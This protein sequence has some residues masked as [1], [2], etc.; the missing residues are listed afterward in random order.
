[1]AETL[2]LELKTSARDE[3][4]DVTQLVRSAT[5]RAQVDSG[6]ALVFCPHT[7]AG[8]TLQENTDPNVRADM[9][10]QLRH[11]VPQDP[12]FRHAEGNADAHIKSSLIGSSVTLMVDKGKLL[13]GPWQAI[14]FCEFDGP[15]SRKL[16]VKVISG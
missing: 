12:Q 5:K 11:L 1:M 13:L 14:Y 10:A 3:M 2:T 9:S 4:I 15:R 7:T 6:L 8:V 16:L